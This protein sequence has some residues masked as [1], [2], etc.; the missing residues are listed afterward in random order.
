MI[1][2]LSSFWRSFIIGGS[3]SASYTSV[4][5]PDISIIFG[6][7]L[8]NG[9]Q[10]YHATLVLNLP[11]G[12]KAQTEISMGKLSDMEKLMSDFSALQ[13]SLRLTLE[14]LTESKDLD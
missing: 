9:H 11:D 13:N 12:T 7:S 14:R 10:I 8:I 4:K 2:E 3:P 1:E 5:R 6:H